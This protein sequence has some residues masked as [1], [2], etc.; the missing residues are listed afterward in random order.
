[1]ILAQ[2]LIKASIA[3]E[4]V[5]GTLSRYDIYNSMFSQTSHFR[6]DTQY[7][8]QILDH[9]HGKIAIQTPYKKDGGLWNQAGNYA[10]WMAEARTV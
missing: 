8:I 7:L 2:K 10:T 4:P 5:R 1:M 6:V 3:R 9:I